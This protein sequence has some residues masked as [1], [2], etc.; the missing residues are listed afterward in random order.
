[1]YRYLNIL[2]GGVYTCGQLKAFTAPSET[3]SSHFIILPLRIMT[4]SAAPFCSIKEISSRGLPLTTR[5]SYQLPVFIFWI[6]LFPGQVEIIKFIG[7][8]WDIRALFRAQGIQ[9]R[10]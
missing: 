3:G 2:F 6:V 5:K 9:R 7:I 4:E 10:L 1:M 8:D